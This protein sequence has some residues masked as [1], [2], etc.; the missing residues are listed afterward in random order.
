MFGLKASSVPNW[1]RKNLRSWVVTDCNSVCSGWPPPGRR[2][3]GGAKPVISP[4]GPMKALPPD[5]EGRVISEP[6]SVMEF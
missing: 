2:V 3:V 5:V 4:L 6:S 1:I